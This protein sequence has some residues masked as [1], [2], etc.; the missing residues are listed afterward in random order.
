MVQKWNIEIWYEK[1]WLA[2]NFQHDEVM[3]LQLWLL[4]L[5]YSE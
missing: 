2:S 3:K 5:I 1:S 4:A